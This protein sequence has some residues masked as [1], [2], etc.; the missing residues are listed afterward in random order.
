MIDVLFVQG[1]GASVH[2]DWDRKLVE[3]LRR[4]LGA[5]YD[6]RY[7]RMPNEADPELATWRSTLERELATL[8]PGAVVVGHSVGGTVAL[9][10]VADWPAAAVLGAIILIAAPFIGPGGWQSDEMAPRADLAESLPA[11][12]PILLYHGDLDATVPVTHV[13]RYA[14]ALPRAQVRRLVG[15]NHQLNDDL[16]EIA[17]EIRALETRAAGL[18]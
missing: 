6:V 7:P 14:E 15:R 2:D 9:R 12:V 18:R 4:G 5:G 3:S 8:R 13:E 1:A 17:A 11:G 16:S 10:V